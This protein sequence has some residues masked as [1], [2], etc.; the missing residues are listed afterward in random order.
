[1]RLRDLVY[2]ISRYP[3]VLQLGALIVVI[4]ITMGFIMHL[5]EPEMFPTV[6]DGVWFAIVTASTIGYGDTSPETVR[7]KAFAM[8]FIMFGAG[9]MTFYMAKLASSFV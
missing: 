4:L 7:G 2:Y 1:M 9:F 5:V 8:V 6:F 3:P